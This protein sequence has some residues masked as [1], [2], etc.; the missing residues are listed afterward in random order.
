MGKYPYS[1]EEWDV[2]CEKPIFIQG[3][4]SKSH[5]SRKTPQNDKYDGSMAGQLSIPLIKIRDK[6]KVLML[7]NIKKKYV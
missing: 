1:I 2:G 4:G 6:Y 3:F 5:P 7:F